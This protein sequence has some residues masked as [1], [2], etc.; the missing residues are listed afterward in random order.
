[1][2]FVKL[3]GYV[4]AFMPLL[5]V[6]IFIL[7]WK[8]VK[9]Q[10]KPLLFYAAASF[11]LFGTGNFIFGNKEINGVL[12]NISVLAELVLACYYILK[13]ILRKSFSL[14]FFIVTGAYFFFWL[15]RILF[16]DASL[17]LNGLPEMVA[18]LVL[19]LLSMYYLL[20]LSAAE[21][22]LYFQKLPSF[23]IVS[24]FLLYTAVKLLVFISYQYINIVTAIIEPGQ[25]NMMNSIATAI[26]FALI[27]MG[28]LCSRRNTSSHIFFQSVLF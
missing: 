20:S 19:L 15:Y 6:L 5:T 27:C 18:S 17:T 22:I 13:I 14:Q 3:I 8:G 24:G 12:Y 28:L 2:D 1:M 9:E 25:V 7:L 26:E 23:W 4:G 16:A 11:L 10:H 21:E